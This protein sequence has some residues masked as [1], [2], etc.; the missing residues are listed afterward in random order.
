MTIDDLLKIVKKYNPEE[1]EI[2][3]RAYDYADKLHKGQYRQSG[4][5]YIMY[6]LNILMTY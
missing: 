4:E 3:K 1:V 6:P 5:P 2:I